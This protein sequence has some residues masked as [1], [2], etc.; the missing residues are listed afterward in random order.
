MAGEGEESMMMAE[1]VEETTITSCS[2]EW[3]DTTQLYYHASSGFYHDP[4][5]GWYYSTRDGLYYAFRNGNYELMESTDSRCG[6]FE[7]CPSVTDEPDITTSVMMDE[8]QYNAENLNCDGF[9]NPVQPPSEWLEETLINLYLSGYSNSE[10]N[11]HTTS[12][13]NELLHDNGENKDLLGSQNVHAMSPVIPACHVNLES[14]YVQEQKQDHHG[15]EIIV[16][17]DN[18]TEEE[19][20]QAQYGQ[21]MQFD[22]TINIPVIDLWDWSMVVECGKGVSR[23]VGRLVKRSAK[24]HQSLPSGGSLLRTAAIHEV[25]LNLVRVAT[26]K[27]YKLRTPSV[28]YLETLLTYD[29]ADPTKDWGFPNLSTYIQRHTSD[30]TNIPK[31]RNSSGSAC[32]LTRKDDDT[33]Y[34]DRAAQRRALHGGF[35]VGPGQKLLNKEEEEMVLSEAEAAIMSFGP[36]SYSRRILE[37]MGWKEGDA[38]GK[39]NQGM[40]EPLQAIGNKGNA[41]LGWNKS[42]Y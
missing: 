31:S 6:D 8:K 18:A 38:L 9:D 36:G 23:L 2:F 41:G 24:L 16:A 13:G 14:E 28:K 21:S 26:G 17:G 33:K 35:G 11:I 22:D 34:I 42:M 7:A 40:L 37:S 30:T 27:V 4:H 32:P 5:A 15:D 25:H 12:E 3:D 19:T 10:N 1:S 39:T 29:A 20:W